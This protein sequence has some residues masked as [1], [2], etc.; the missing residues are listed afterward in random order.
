M[1]GFTHLHTHSYYSFLEGLPAPEELV[2]AAVD[3]GMPALALTDHSS[4]TGA[5]EFY[6]LCLDAGIQPIIGLQVAVTSPLEAQPLVGDL[7][8]LA[9]NLAGWRNLCRISSAVQADPI[10]NAGQILPFSRLAEETQ[11][12]LCLTAGSQGCFDQLVSTNQADTALRYLGHLKD[13]FPGDLYVELQR[14]TPVEIDLSRQLASVAMQ[15][16]TPVVAANQVYYLANDQADLQLL[17]TAI[18]LNKSINTL[19]ASAAPPLSSRFTTTEEMLPR[20]SDLPAALSATGEIADRCRLELPLGIPRFPQANVPE[21][22][23][24]I[25]ALYEKAEAGAKRHRP[26]AASA[27]PVQADDAGGRPPGGEAAEDP[28]AIGRYPAELGTAL[29]VRPPAALYALSISAPARPSRRYA[30]RD[31]C[32]AGRSSPARSPGP[33]LPGS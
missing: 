1:P 28:Q 9:Q 21:G 18:R 22:Q 27:E 32:G 5:I 31:W 13:L 15:I 17:V 33:V 8:L 2:Q 30:R 4:L 20:F 12:L 26:A 24:M 19:S 7:V 14:R 10:N 6:D 29:T 3:D 23:T 16:D 25:A 11:G